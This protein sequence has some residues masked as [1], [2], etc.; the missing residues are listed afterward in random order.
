MR[1]V[2]IDKPKTGENYRNSNFRSPQGRKRSSQGHIWI[3][4]NKAVIQHTFLYSIIK[5][6]IVKEIFILT[7]HEKILNGF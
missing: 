2:L 3:V 1:H 5:Q 6:F 7:K 4:L